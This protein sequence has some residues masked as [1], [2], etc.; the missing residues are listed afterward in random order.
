MLLISALF[1]AILRLAD[2]VL[3]CD[4]DLGRLSAVTAGNPDKRVL[5]A[6]AKKTVFGAGAPPGCSKYRLI[7]VMSRSAN[8]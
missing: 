8:A 6:S 7:M 4:P 1:E 2:S 3:A 5:D